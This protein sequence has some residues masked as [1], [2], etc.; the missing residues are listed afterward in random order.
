MEIDKLYDVEDGYFK[1]LSFSESGVGADKRLNYY[2]VLKNARNE[3]VRPN[4]TILL[5]DRKGLQTGMARIKREAASPP[6]QAEDLKPGETRTFTAQ[7][8]MTRA[9]PPRYFLVETP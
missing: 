4:A 7:L 5:F 2:A 1:K 3:P 9:E 6:T 8:E